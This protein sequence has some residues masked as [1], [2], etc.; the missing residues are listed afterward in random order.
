MRARMNRTKVSLFLRYLAITLIPISVLVA[1]GTISIIMNDRYVARQI[2]AASFRT[3]EQIRN[4]VDFTFAELDALDIIFSSSSEFLAALGRILSSPDLDLEQS[5]LLSVLQ[6][7]VN[8][9]AFARRDVESIYVYIGNDRDRF[10]TTTDGI[11]D[12]AG[13]SDRDWYLS[14]LSHAADDPSW[15]ETR[16]LNRLPAVEQGRPVV[17]IYR[18]LYPLAGARLPGVVVLNIHRRF[19]A[20]LL[21]RMKDSADQRIVI[22]DEDGAV[23]YTDFPEAGVPWRG[24][25][26]DVSAFRVVAAEGVRW[27]AARLDSPR[28]GWAYLSFTPADRFYGVSRPLRSLNI[29]VVGLSVLLGTLV[30]F[31]ASRRGF[32]SIEGLLDVVDAAEK[33]GPLPSVPARAGR[34]FSHITYSVLRTFLEHRYLRVQMSERRYRLKT[35]ELLA[36]QSQMNPHFLFNTLEAINWKAIELSRGPNKINDMIRD[37]SGILKYVLQPPSGRETLANEIKHARDYL[38]IQRVRFKNRFSVRWDLQSGLERRKVIRFLLQPLLE[39]AIYHGL[40]EK[41]GRGLITI[42][43]REA[44]GRLRIVVA[45]DGVGMTPRRLAEVR[46]RLDDEGSDAE[47]GSGSIGLANTSRRIHLTFGDGYGLGLESE[48]GRGTSVT[49]TLP[50]RK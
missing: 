29:A 24:D 18:R 6:N 36:L 22:L 26:G 7:I 50:S 5:K 12:F 30:T 45:D 34:G 10:L 16:V 49:V 9:S 37:L 44:R 13:Y 31:Y 11:V 40:R 48:P 8:V 2:R 42:R 4:S 3:L 43:V 35:L 25:G 14:Y 28:H 27:V 1:T 47:T 33:G 39:N 41:Q 17:T 38:R 23:I 32:R 21:E 15:T 46:R 19:F 20:D